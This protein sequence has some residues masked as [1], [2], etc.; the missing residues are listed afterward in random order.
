[1]QPVD[2]GVGQFGVEAELESI[3]AIPVVIAILPVAVAG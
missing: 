2:D 3:L 1:V